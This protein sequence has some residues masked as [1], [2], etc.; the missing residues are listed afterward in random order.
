ML[1]LFAFPFFL[2]GPSYKRA[3]SAYNDAKTR[4]EQAKKWTQKDAQ[5]KITLDLDQ[6]W[7]W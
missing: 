3:P 5:L 7:L 2:V 1:L 4:K 6:R